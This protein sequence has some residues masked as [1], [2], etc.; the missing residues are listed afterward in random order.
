MFCSL[1]SLVHKLSCLLLV[2][3]LSQQGLLFFTHAWQVLTRCTATI[4][5]LSKM[6]CAGIRKCVFV[7]LNHQCFTLALELLSLAS[8]SSVQICKNMLH[9]QRLQKELVGRP[10]V[11]SPLLVS[12]C[13]SIPILRAL[14]KIC[15][16]LVDVTGHL[17]SCIGR[18]VDL[19]CACTTHMSGSIY[20]ML[21]LYISYIHI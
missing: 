11:N 18:L 15:N 1:Q 8:S 13:N 9:R 3:Q 21:C 4:H 14:C 20:G 10:Y 2:A 12:I 17:L 7:T 19:I 16:Q 5:P 6:M